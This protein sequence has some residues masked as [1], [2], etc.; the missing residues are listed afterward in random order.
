MTDNGYFTL[1]S[2]CAIEMQGSGKENI[3]TEAISIGEI[4][5]LGI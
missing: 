1:I 4:L 2:V 3:M 5:F